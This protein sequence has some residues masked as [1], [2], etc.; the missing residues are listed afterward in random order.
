MELK[1]FTGTFTYINYLQGCWIESL[2]L[3]H[4]FTMN[5]FVNLIPYDWEA[6]NVVLDLYGEKPLTLKV[7]KK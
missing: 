1:T 4:N 2:A 7:R 3:L 6:H 5:S